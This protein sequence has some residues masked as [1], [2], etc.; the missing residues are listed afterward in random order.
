[1]ERLIEGEEEDRMETPTP[2]AAPERLSDE[3]VAMAASGDAEKV[4]AARRLWTREVAALLALEVEERRAAE[5]PIPTSERLPEPGVDVLFWQEPGEEW[6]IG[7]LSPDG[8]RW[9]SMIG[10]SDKEDVPCWLPLPPAP[11]GEES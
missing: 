11:G 3:Q 2:D 7:F 6:E 5:R 4:A 9:Y 10:P 1:M 8:E